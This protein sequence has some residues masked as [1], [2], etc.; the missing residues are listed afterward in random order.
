MNQNRDK[1]RI[2]LHFLKVHSWAMYAGA[3]FSLAGWSPFGWE[4]Y[5]T[6]IPLVILHEWGK[7]R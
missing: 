3:A 4:F 6:V 1:V 2:L 7:E 5:A